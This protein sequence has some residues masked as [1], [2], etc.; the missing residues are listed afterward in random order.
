MYPSNFSKLKFTIKPFFTSSQKA[1]LRHLQRMMFWKKY[2]K[3]KKGSKRVMDGHSFGHGLLPSTSQVSTKPELSITADEVSDLSVTADLSLS[4]WKGR[5]EFPN[6]AHTQKTQE[7]YS[8]VLMIWSNK[9][10][11]LIK[12]MPTSHIGQFCCY[13]FILSHSLYPI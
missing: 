10:T 11:L 13:L 12:P 6:W 7:R 1:W 2:C 5:M 8:H 9:H 4:Y 3:K